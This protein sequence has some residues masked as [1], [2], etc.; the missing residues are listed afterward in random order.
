[1]ASS[2]EQRRAELVPALAKLTTSRDFRTDLAHVVPEHTVLTV[3]PVLSDD[4]MGYV[5]DRL[6]EG[7]GGGV[8]AMASDGGF[9][10]AV[11]WPATPGSRE[12]IT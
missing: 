8:V 11:A 10:L 3:I 7:D 1:M 5:F 9:C 6:S 4:T 2:R 12:A